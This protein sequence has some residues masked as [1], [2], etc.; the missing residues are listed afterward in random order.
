MRDELRTPLNPVLMTITDLERDETLPEPLRQQMTVV[1]RNVELEARL[2]DDLLDST[3]IANGKLQLQRSVVD[4]RD[5]L[6][7]A[8]A[9]VEG[10]ARAKNVSLRIATCSSACPV[11][12]DPTRLQQV[13]WNLLKNAVK[14][15]P[16]GGSVQVDCQTVG[17]GAIRVSVQDDGIG[18]SPED[19]AKIFN[20]FEQGATGGKHRFG[21]L[22]LGLAISEA[23]VAMHD[24]TLKVH[25]E[26][27]GRGATFTV[28]LP[29]TREKK[30]DAVDHQT[31]FVPRR[32]L[33]LLVVEDHEATAAVMA[34]L[35][36]RRGYT[37][38]LA[39]SISSALGILATTPIDL[40]ISDLGL[41][42]GT[43]GELMARIHATRSLPGIALSGY[44]TEQDVSSSRSAGFRAHLTKP[45]DIE[46][47]DREI[48]SLSREI[49]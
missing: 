47:L 2:I 44:G 34:R 39:S 29:L 9:V 41:P 38:T 45:V 37:V 33:R 43:G 22:G 32:A 16:E 17:D 11:N 14:F 5:L 25:S 20:A 40:L 19:C 13:F 23:L 6:C 10:D 7:R 8:V 30:P 31:E 27:P 4:A 1:R 15:T 35:L 18:I 48:Q 46:M 42:D 49:P 3:R 24:G 26:G 21:G 12:G 28:E 36:K